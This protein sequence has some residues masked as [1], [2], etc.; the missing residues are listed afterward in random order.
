MLWINIESTLI[1]KRINSKVGRARQNSIDVDVE[2]DNFK[3]T[4]NATS[5]EECLKKCIET[6]KRCLSASYAATFRICYIYFRK[7]VQLKFQKDQNYITYQ[8]VNSI[9]NQSRMFLFLKCFLLILLFLRLKISPSNSHYFST[10]HNK[11]E[12]TLINLYHLD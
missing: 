8:R 11:S 10:I 6:P 4:F 2:S 1:F 5:P 12:Q 3:N 7:E 9:N